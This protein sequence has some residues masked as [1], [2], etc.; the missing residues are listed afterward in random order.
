[1]TIGL[2]IRQRN[3]DKSFSIIAADVKTQTPVYRKSICDYPRSHEL[4]TATIENA[5]TSGII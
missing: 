2:K 3:A 4:E 5:K 1:M